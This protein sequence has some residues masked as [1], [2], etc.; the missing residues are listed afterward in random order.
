VNGSV[1]FQGEAGAFSEEA[2]L[3]LFGEVTCVGYPTFDALVDAVDR[4]EVE[5]GLLPCENAI[6]GSI[7]RSY[8]LLAEH[9]NVR[10]VDETVHTIAQML[11]GTPGSRLDA[12]ERVESH[13]VALEQCRVFLQNH[14]QMSTKIVED[15]AGAIRTIVE[16]GDPRVAAIGPALAAQRYGGVI[17]ARDIHDDLENATRF[18]VIAKN[19]VSRRNLGRAC[20]AFRLEHRAGSLRDAL[21]LL[22][23]RGLNLR[24]LVAR[25]ARA[26]P[27]EYAFYIEFDCPREDVLAQLVEEIGLGARVLGFY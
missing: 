16:R 27:F 3:V 15:T 12:I 22:A 2:A 20:V 1:G 18:F 10:I 5:L 4:G 24:S 21:G 11:V 7:A 14:P 23:D 13:P 25:P 8:D 17:L 19:P 26:R 6:Y 9:E